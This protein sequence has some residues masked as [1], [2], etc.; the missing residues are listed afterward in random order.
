MSQH[1]TDTIPYE[2][3]YTISYGEEQQNRMLAGLIRRRYPRICNSWIE[4]AIQDTFVFAATRPN[5]RV[6]YE[7][8]GAQAWWKL[9]RVAAVRRTRDI[10]RCKGNQNETIEDLPL[11]QPLTPFDDALATE[12]LERIDALIES[13]T[14]SFRSGQSNA[15]ISD[16]DL[17]D[18]I[19][20][21]FETGDSDK[22]VAERHNG[23]P[24]A[25]I[26]KIKNR[27]KK[28]VTNG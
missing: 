23:I 15:E 13:E 9:M 3:F 11:S 21:R 5:F 7:D 12:M 4:D 25:Y 2:Q 8:Q 1:N 6:V 24:R 27:I 16:A 20:D 28:V 14:R 19:R 26:N 18:A 22:A 10:W 17:E